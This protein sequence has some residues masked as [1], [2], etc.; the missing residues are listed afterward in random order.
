MNDVLGGVELIDN[1]LGGRFFS[2]LYRLVV[3]LSKPR[4]QNRRLFGIELDIDGPVLALDK[5]ADLALAI[6]DESQGDGLYAAR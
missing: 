2:D 4:S 1:R 6:D 5:G 3:L